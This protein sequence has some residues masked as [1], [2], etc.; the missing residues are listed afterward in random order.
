MESIIEPISAKRLCVGF[1]K[2]HGAERI[3]LK[4][5]MRNGSQRMLERW[6][7]GRDQKY[8][9]VNQ[10]SNIPLFHSSGFYLV[11]ERKHV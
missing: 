7:S 8:F 5:K 4:S 2:A 10:H 1:K 11:L 6:N 9:S 3:A